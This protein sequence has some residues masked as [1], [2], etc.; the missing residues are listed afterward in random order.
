[1]TTEAQVGQLGLGVWGSAE[2]D[3]EVTQLALGVWARIPRVTIYYTWPFRLLKPRKQKP[4]R[5]GSAKLGP[6]AADGVQQ[7]VTRTDGGG[8]WRFDCAFNVYSIDEVRA[9]RAWASF[10]DNGARPFIMPLVDLRFAPRDLVGD[11]L[12][13][14]EPMAAS[15]DYFGEVAAY[16]PSPIVVAE[17]IQAATLR[18]TSVRIQIDQGATLKGGEFFSILHPVSGWRLYSISHVT[19]ELSG[20][21][22]DVEIRPPL[23]EAVSIGSGN[24]VAEFDFPRCM[25]RLHPDSAAQMA[26]EITNLR[27]G[28]E[29]NIAFVEHFEG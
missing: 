1:M 25:M 9:L 15:P 3:A 11:V 8:I 18:A 26:V 6:V 22:F 10:L 28:Q 20:G 12:R 2:S 27:V 13:K 23:R 5:I 14:P 7:Q 16:A 21:I 4:Y 24:P 29:L 17:I 19:N